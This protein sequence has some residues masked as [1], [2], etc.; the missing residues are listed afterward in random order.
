[1]DAFTVTDISA[2][3]APEGRH[4]RDILP[5]CRTI[6]IFG[7]VMP[8]RYF[9]GTSREKT[10][11]TRLLKVTLEKAAFAL[12]K[13]LEETGSMAVAILPSDLLDVK[14]GAIRGLLSLK[15]CARDAGLGTIGE[16][17]LLI[18]PEFGNRLALAAVITDREIEPP[19]PVPVLPQC[20]R[21]NRCIQSC[22]AGA[23]SNGTVD[24]MA[25][26]C[27]TDYVPRLFLPVVR[28]GVRAMPG[29]WS[30]RCM[31][32]IMD[33]AESIIDI[34]ATCAECVTS[35]PYFHKGKR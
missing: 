1:M 4:P 27:L 23:I 34:Q 31:T 17:T 22:P 10:A 5:S 12:Q 15:H 14:E 35:C 19:L 3:R 16:N 8:D 13:Q 20:T 26:R 29:R 6:I 33:R 11:E 32:V 2:I 7:K 21:C 28:W 25:C 9:T 18:N 30:A 24:C